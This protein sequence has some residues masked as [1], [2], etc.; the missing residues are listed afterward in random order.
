MTARRLVLLRH[1]R[2]EQF[3]ASDQARALTARGRRD[4]AAAG[5]WLREQGL[6]P[7]EAIV[8]SA[9]RTKE[10]WACLADAAGTA[11]EPTIDGAVYQGS[12][13]VALEAVRGVPGDPRTLL[14][15]GHNPTIASLTMLLDDGAGDAAVLGRV[16]DGYPPCT[17]AVL[18]V[19]CSWPHLEYAGATLRALHTAREG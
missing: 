10:T 7:D 3:A 12:T 17:A 8:S 5:R 6:L 2:A 14:L 4:A 19:H 13:D 11:I 18:E 16:A 15:L 1:A 9:A